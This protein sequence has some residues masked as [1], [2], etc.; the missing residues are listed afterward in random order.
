VTEL[1]GRVVVLSPHLDDAVLSLGAAMAQA[2]D[3]AQLEIVTVLAGDPESVRPA[4]PWDAQAG[5]QTEGAA[6][7]ARRAED[8]VA[9]RRIGAESR[10]LPF[11]DEQYPRGADDDAVWTAL[12]P[13][14]ALADAVLVPGFPLSH[15]DHLWLTRLVLARA[16]PA[17]QVGFYVEQPYAAIVHRRPPNDPWNGSPP[18]PVRWD[19]LAAGPAA[20]AAKREATAAYGSQLRLMF[21]RTRMVKRMERYESVRGGEGVGWISRANR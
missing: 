8:R 6:A 17:Q 1:R 20:R 2:R 11:S 12:A 21:P 16:V 5:F 10:W 4:G 19:T 3:R 15:G 14:L 13:M 7:T 9:C 18:P